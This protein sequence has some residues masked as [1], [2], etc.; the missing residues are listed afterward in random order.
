MCPSHYSETVISLS[1]LTK[2]QRFHSPERGHL[3]DYSVFV[4]ASH[5]SGANVIGLTKIFDALESFGK[6]RKYNI[7]CARVRPRRL[8]PS[9]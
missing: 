5:T 2:K 8:E 3:E 4:S 1:S 9:R 7:L 6:E